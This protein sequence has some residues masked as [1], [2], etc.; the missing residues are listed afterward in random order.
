[1]R[2]LGQSTVTAESSDSQ[3][4]VQ[5]PAVA[6]AAAAAGNTMGKRGL[7]LC[8][9]SR[10]SEVAAVAAVAAAAVVVEQH[11]CCRASVAVGVTVAVVDAAAGYGDAAAAGRD[12]EDGV[13]E[14]N[15]YC[16]TFAGVGCC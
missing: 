4:R 2:L 5:H 15:R 16:L 9:A 10:C 1:V 6:V 8:S 14:K 13:E 3:T 11:S 7:Q 12:A